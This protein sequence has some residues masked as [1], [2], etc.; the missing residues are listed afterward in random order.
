[1]A[2]IIVVGAEKKGATVVLAQKDPQGNLQSWRV[3]LTEADRT[4]T[5]TDPRDL[6][7]VINN[8]T[9]DPVRVE[10]YSSPV[11]PLPRVDHFLYMRTVPGAVA[12]INSEMFTPNQEVTR[13]GIIFQINP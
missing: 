2:H 10:L 11:P 12:G 3:L 13:G 5:D 6:A 9:G 7:V 1:M 8:S 4:I